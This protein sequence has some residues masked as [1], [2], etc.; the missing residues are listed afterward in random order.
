MGNFLLLVQMTDDLRTEMNYYKQLAIAVEEKLRSLEIARE[1]E[2][3]ENDSGTCK[4]LESKTKKSNSYDS[5]TE[6]SSVTETE[7]S[8]VGSGPNTETVID[9]PTRENQQEENF[10]SLDTSVTESIG[11]TID[12][13]CKSCNNDAS[14]ERNEELF[15]TSTCSDTVTASTDLNQYLDVSPPT[16]RTSATVT[17]ELMKPQVPKTLDIIPIT[18]EV[19]EREISHDS[20]AETLLPNTPP[21]LVR[22]G[23]YILETPS[24]ML[25]AHMQ[26]ELKNPEYIPT[27]TTTAMKRRE[28]NIS[29]AKS[30]WENQIKNKQFVI[31]DNSRSNSGQTRCR[32]N[33][34]STMS[35]QKIFKSFSYSKTSSSLGTRQ[36]ARSVDCIQTM[37]DREL[38]CK[39]PGGTK[40][41][42]CSQKHG[43]RGGSS[44]T[45][46]NNSQKWNSNRN[47]SI[48]NLANK[49]GGSLGNL[50]NSEGQ[51]GQTLNIKNSSAQPTIIED[52][53]STPSVS[54]VVPMSEKLVI[55]FK[56]IQRKHEE[57]MAEL[58]A[59]Q[60]REQ[61]NMQRE[62]EKQ[63]VLLL[64]Q[65]EKTFPG[66]SIPSPT[67]TA[68][69]ILANTS[70]S[71]IKSSNL[72]SNQEED[73]IYSSDN[74]DPPVAKCLL[75]YIYPLNGH[76]EILPSKNV[77]V[78]SNV[79]SL[80]TV[81]SDKLPSE[82][83]DVV[84]TYGDNKVESV[85]RNTNS[86]DKYCNVS[87][88]LFPLDSN[89]MHVPVPVNIHYNA[90]H[91]SM[92]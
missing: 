13:S 76:C 53:P 74:N 11:E 68:P 3:E 52:K 59:K 61:N 43:F 33:S 22:Q 58:I 82:Y 86:T 20:F 72:V 31:P 50:T 54:K 18:V 70:A 41:N 60:Q 38:V 87:R 91:V 56:E 37:L 36:S 77:T 63:Q 26:T 83:N 49:L 73:D 71:P 32:R 64:G 66:I 39:S 42:N 55:I 15:A 12:R 45:K 1:T 75:D 92:N 4:I 62:F 23:S 8:T 40:K 46:N 14:I 7:T 9:L 35:N 6:D 84:K 90:K 24:P 47:V 30:E 88:E 21:K 89:T 34:M 10:V 51:P 2:N 69:N 85:H 25:L 29:Q 57:Q 44:A 16:Q 65:I 19:P 48:L 67:E 28:W 81:K 80:G 27:A 17:P 5:T 78:K 79:D